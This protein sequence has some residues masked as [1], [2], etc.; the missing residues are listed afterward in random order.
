MNRPDQQLSQ[1]TLFIPAKFRFRS[2]IPLWSPS[3]KICLRIPR[4]KCLSCCSSP[5]KIDVTSPSDTSVSAVMIQ[6]FLNFAVKSIINQIQQETA[7][8]IPAD[9]MMYYLIENDVPQ[10]GNGTRAEPIDAASNLQSSLP[11]PERQ[12]LTANRAHP[13]RNHRV[14]E[15]RKQERRQQKLPV[16]LDT[17]LGRRRQDTEHY[18]QID[19][20]I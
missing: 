14:E 6:D 12:H 15:R 1:Q 19:F 2:P 11:N 5:L 4:V 10:S 18:P 16:L 7:M 13:Y 8:R 20:A 9:A 17:R 3:F